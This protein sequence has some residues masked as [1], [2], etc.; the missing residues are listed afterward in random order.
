MGGHAAGEVA[1]SL[2]IASMA[3]LDSEPPGGDMLAELAAAVAAA[4]TRLQEMIIANPAVEGMGTTLTALFWSD[5]HAAVSHI[6]DSRGYLLRD[7]ELYQI[8]HDHT[9]VQSL[10]SE[11]SVR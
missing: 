3:K 8:T 10:I 7:G 9:L 1:S 5:G 6:G 4:N 2:T 11:E